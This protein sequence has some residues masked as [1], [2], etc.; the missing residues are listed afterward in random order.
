MNKDRINFK[1]TGTG[2]FADY[3]VDESTDGVVLSF[4]KDESSNPDHANPFHSRDVGFAVLGNVPP[5]D[6]LNMVAGI[7]N[8]LYHN[9]GREKAEDLINLAHEL[10]KKGFE[11][12]TK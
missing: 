12:Q 5:R 7:L 3:Q 6:M 1:V 4:V 2:E 9:M 10:A 8:A 11:E